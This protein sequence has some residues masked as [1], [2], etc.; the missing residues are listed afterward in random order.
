MADEVAG[1]N[2]PVTQSVAG[3]SPATQQGDDTRGAVDVAQTIS[4]SA[5]ENFNE[6]LANPTAEIDAGVAAESTAKSVPADESSLKVAEPN[7]SDDQRVDE[8][9]LPAGEATGTMATDGA[10]PADSVADH[11]P[12]L[13]LKNL[14]SEFAWPSTIGELS[15]LRIYLDVSTDACRVVLALADSSNT[16]LWLHQLGEKLPSVQSITASSDGVLTDVLAQRSS[17]IRSFGCRAQEVTEIFGV[18]HVE[19]YVGLGPWHE[20]FSAEMLDSFEGIWNELGQTA[21]AVQN[22]QNLGGSIEQGMDQQLLR[23]DAKTQ[24]LRITLPEEVSYTQIAADASKNDV[25][26]LQ[27]ALT[28]E[29]RNKAE[30]DN[31]I[32]GSWVAGHFVESVRNLHAIGGENKVEPKLPVEGLENLE[33]MKEKTNV[34]SS[35]KLVSEIIDLGVS[36]NPAKPDVRLKPA[37]ENATVRADYASGNSEVVIYVIAPTGLDFAGIALDSEEYSAIS[38]VAARSGATVVLSAGSCDS[39]VRLQGSDS[40]TRTILQPLAAFV[41]NRFCRAG[42][43]AGPAVF[44]CLFDALDVRGNRRLDVCTLA[45][46]LRTLGIPGDAAE[47]AKE[48]VG[49]G[50]EYVERATFGKLLANKCVTPDFVVFAVREGLSEPLQPRCKQYVLS[51][52]CLTS[53]EFHEVKAR[54]AKNIAGSN[55]HGVVL[56]LTSRGRSNLSL[57]DYEERIRVELRAASEGLPAKW[58]LLWY[59]GPA[60]VGLLP[61]QSGGATRPSF[62]VPPKTANRRTL[63]EWLRYLL[64]VRR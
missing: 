18:A 22:F 40:Q 13:D 17:F 7:S 35:E 34:G 20:Q 38:E 21:T 64:V 8:P 26:R 28:F 46:G 23:E 9:D 2:E 4:P 52:G 59:S 42:Q 45:E 6:N 16:R 32:H 39:I 49:P 29:S 27:G 54:E 36:P 31:S 57:S 61:P 24:V 56:I 51:Q 25:G 5:D 33:Y 3:E 19:L 1:E 63:V 10:I 48:I 43:V 62:A 53:S 30:V 44:E 37:P 11:G 50:T 47:T 58:P 55:G 41:E 12:P 60:E 14:K 15:L